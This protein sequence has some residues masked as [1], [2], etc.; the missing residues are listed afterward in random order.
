LKVYSKI[1]EVK[2]WGPMELFPL[3]KY[4]EEEIGRAGISRGIAILSIEGATPA[5][6]VL[7]RGL[8]KQFL[9][10][11]T[12]L[13]PFTIWRHGNAYA[14]LISTF[15]STSTTIPIESSKL[16]LPDDYD[17]Y[18]LETRSVHNHTRRI[19]LLLH[20]ETEILSRLEN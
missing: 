4:I 20:G 17:I 16:L 18:L 3:R 10:N 14:H 6:V 5:L 15:I 8:E 9:N 13:V 11:I 1:I 19:Y 12:E 2:T 7:Q